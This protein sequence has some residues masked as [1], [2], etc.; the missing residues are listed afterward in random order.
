MAKRRIVQ[1]L[2]AAATNSYVAG[3]A[4]GKIYRGG[5][6]G[7]C[8]PGLNCYSCPGALA[9]CPLGSLQAVLGSARLTHVTLYVLGFLVLF[10]ALCG[11]FVCGW[12]CPF[13]LIQEWLN[14][15]PFFRKI[16]TF[17]GD[18]TLR[19]LKYA[20]L[21]VFVILMPM[22]LVNPFGNGTPYFCELICPA[23]TLEG[24]I[25][26]VALNRDLQA[27][28]GWLYAWKLVILAA[29]LL[30]SVVI[31]RPFCKY[32]CPLGAIYA[33]FNP[34]AI[35]RIRIDERQCTNCGACAQSCPMNVD[36]RSDPNSLECIRCGKCV[37]ACNSGAIKMGFLPQANTHGKKPSK[38]KT[39]KSS[40]RL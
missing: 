20:L 11:R 12:L 17:R 33:L 29:V 7:I 39:R 1:V 4:E 26:L 13:G 15:I 21:A 10:G 22:F 6:K 34:V 28:V 5:L 3:F 2:W 9:A 37:N 16:Y 40:V 27:A 32:L 30:A 23:G 18:R 35:H 31:Y 25:P 8:V 36:L 14:K 24:G 38:K 19:W